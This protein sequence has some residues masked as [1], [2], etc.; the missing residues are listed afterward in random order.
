MLFTVYTYTISTFFNTNYWGRVS[1]C[2]GLGRVT[3]SSLG[4][5]LSC[6]GPSVTVSGKTYT[7]SCYAKLNLSGGLLESVGTVLLRSLAA[8]LT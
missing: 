8:R 7:Y 6:Y 2:Y 1:I 3:A 4:D 5:L